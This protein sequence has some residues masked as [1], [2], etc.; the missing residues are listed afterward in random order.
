MPGETLIS[1]ILRRPL[2]GNVR[3]YK[4]LE[5][6]KGDLVVWWYGGIA[7]NSQAKTVPRVAVFFRKLNEDGVPSVF[8]RKEVALTHLGLLRIGTIWR[9]GTCEAEAIFQTEKLNISF[10]EGDWNFVS[11]YN[12]AQ[13][14]E[15][16][17]VNPK[18]YP[19]NFSRDRNWLINLPLPDGKNLLIPCLEFYV[20]CYGRSEEVPRILATYHWEEV[21]RRF[22]QPFDQPI[23]PG[24]WPVKLGD[25]LRNGDVV[26][27]AH[28]LYDPYAQLAA[29]RVYS[30]LEAAFGNNEPYAFVQVA[31][32]FQGR[33]DL[34]VSGLWI[35][36]GKT[37]L[38]LRV[39]GCS[40]P[41]DDP[42]QR[43]RENP[44]K[45]EMAAD[46]ENA[47]KAWDG[48]AVRVLKKLPEIIDL[49]D[50]QEPDHGAVRIEIEEDEFEV[51][52]PQRSVIDVWRKKAKSSAG[53]PGDGGDAVSFS[54]GEAY[55]SG[56]GVGHAS[57]H[58]PP[59]MESCG[60]LRDVWNA[61]LYI[62][63]NRP[64][65][66]NTVEWFTFEHGFESSHEPRLIALQPFSAD[67]EDKIATSIRNWPYYDV[68]EKQPRGIL[69]ARAMVGGS[70]VY[71]FEI[72]RRPRK[73]KEEDGTVKDSEESYKGL[74]FTLE[75][76]QEFKPWLKY[77]LS[78]VRYASGVVHRLVKKCPGK[79]HA[80]MHKASA[81]EQVPCESAVVNAF[82][83][84]GVEI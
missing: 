57:I 35:N 71:F 46:S 62:K 42:I 8:I 25:R 75:T 9:N 31:P 30:Q 55:G 40:D 15:D 39:Q 24:Y 34:K 4:P 51:L 76:Q 82:Y 43:D 65:K 1:P 17:P 60:A 6:E 38:A 3:V 29:K 69:V 45:V 61:L 7:K 78:D 63:E 26:F 48:A 27:V 41:Q 79:A 67:S 84:V 66:V 83:K 53:R 64:D 16:N 56:K 18:D 33:A 80:F 20:R 50:A 54:T 21:R 44:N 49:T 13:N 81:D 14:R 23:E 2:K 19:L 77:L 37:F 72:Q 32:W 5:S 58:A 73:K 10:T 52:G 22:C 74:V 36:G 28:T 59:T 11:P 70:L 47:N 68:N 12:C